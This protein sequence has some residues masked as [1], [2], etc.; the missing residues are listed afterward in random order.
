V[1][2]LLIILA[3]IVGGG[4]SHGERAGSDPNVFLAVLGIHSCF[5]F[6]CFNFGSTRQR[7]REVML[8]AGR[9]GA[10]PAVS[11]TGAAHAPVSKDSNRRQE[12][13]HSGHD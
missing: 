8:A 12:H 2:R 1:G 6:G 4:A 3:F 9:T 11:A 7:F 10:I 13:H 5:D